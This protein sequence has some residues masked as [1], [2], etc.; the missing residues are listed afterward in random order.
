M[1][2]V[3]LSLQYYYTGLHVTIGAMNL[4]ILCIKHI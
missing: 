1:Y 3:T 4:I 2:V